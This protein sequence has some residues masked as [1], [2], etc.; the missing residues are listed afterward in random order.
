M[1]QEKS[2]SLSERL[3]L[4]VDAARIGR[5]EE[6]RKHL[7]SV[8]RQDPDN[9]PAM[10]WLA[11][12]L[13]SPEDTIRV[14]ERVLILDPSN[15]RAKAGIVW[16]QSRIEAAKNTLP[17]QPDGLIDPT[18]PATIVHS[19][20]MVDAVS[21]EEMS[22][23]QRLLSGDIQKR[24]KKGAVAHRARR[25][26]KTLLTALLVLSAGILAGLGSAV[27]LTTPSDTLAAWIPGP[28]KSVTTGAMVTTSLE[29]EPA[30]SHMMDTLPLIRYGYDRT[31]DILVFAPPTSNRP[32]L[33]RSGESVFGPSAFSAVAAIAETTLPWRGPWHLVGPD[34]ASIPVDVSQLPYQPAYP[35]EKWI[36]V[37]VTKQ[38][39][40]AW[41]GNVPVYRFATS[42]GLDE[43]PTILGEYHI[44]WKLESTLMT[45][46]GYYLP[47]VPYAMYFH[48][49]YALHGAYWHSNF[50]VPMSHG[51]VNL[52][53]D[54]SKTLFEWA[55]PVIPP[56]YTQ[57]VSSTSNPGTVVVVHE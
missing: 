27:V 55:D 25:N 9:I 20:D 38:E 12:V 42:T 3:R 16:A 24:A 40:T 2:L 53:I 6:A 54:D 30:T 29:F 22:F 13:S 19:E 34:W 51:C 47:D 56:G 46:I 44:Y 33:A 49:D 11:F 18:K 36:Q 57:V 35:G 4:G 52:S 7:L 10:L 39:V 21:E 15:D 43:T 23:R 50:G 26:M 1:K 5:D 41:E 28:V 48:T 31:N 8:L 17:L 32:P 14:L 45:G 37:D